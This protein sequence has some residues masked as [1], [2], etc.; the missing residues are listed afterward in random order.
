MDAG[1][2]ARSSTWHVGGQA[3]L[4]AVLDVPAAVVVIAEI[5]W[6]GGVDDLRAMPTA[7]DGAYDPPLRFVIN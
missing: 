5:A 4:A 3:P 1:H 7:V 6:S 2:L